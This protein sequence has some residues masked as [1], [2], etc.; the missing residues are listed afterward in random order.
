MAPTR[1]WS[2]APENG[3][4]GSGIVVGMCDGLSVLSAKTGSYTVVKL[5]GG[6]SNSVSSAFG[7]L[8]ERA[9]E[10]PWHVVLVR[11]PDQ[12][13]RPR[14]LQALHLQAHLGG[15]RQTVSIGTRHPGAQHATRSADR[16]DQSASKVYRSE[17]R[18]FSLRRRQGAL[19]KS[20]YCLLL[21]TD[22]LAVKH[23]ANSLPRLLYGSL[24]QAKGGL[25]DLE[26]LRAS[27]RWRSPAQPWEMLHEDSGST[28]PTEPPPT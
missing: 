11:M 10:V 17:P 24:A 23:R 14:R 28:G 22:A 13:G 20:R 4:P 16:R 18:R 8:R 1:I 26:F 19:L 5:P 15:D 2:R 21:K 25:C 12:A 3:S 6:S 27:H 9:T 7:P